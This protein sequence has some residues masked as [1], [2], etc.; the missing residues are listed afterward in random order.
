MGHEE[1]TYALWSAERKPVSAVDG[2]LLGTPRAAGSVDLLN[3][4]LNPQDSPRPVAFP[5]EANALMYAQDQAVERDDPGILAFLPVPVSLFGGRTDM[6]VYVMRM[7][8]VTCGKCGALINRM[9]GYEHGMLFD[10]VTAVCPRC[11]GKTKFRQPA[12]RT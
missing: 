12:R 3:L 2:W 4:R 5:S 10:T 1:K 6:E 11:G 9:S 7:T 8:T